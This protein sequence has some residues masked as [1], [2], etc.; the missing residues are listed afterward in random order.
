MKEVKK[1]LTD[2]KATLTKAADSINYS[3]DIKSHQ[4]NIDTEVFAL[5]NMISSLTEHLLKQN[6]VVLGQQLGKYKELL[7][8]AKD[9]V[10]DAQ[11]A[12]AA[13]ECNKVSLGATAT[14]SN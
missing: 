3:A 4:Y 12:L 7:R 5:Y 1:D 8:Q 2:L 14:Y 13:M 10:C 6:W 11:S 9:E